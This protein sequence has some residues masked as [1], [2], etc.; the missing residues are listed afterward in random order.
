MNMNLP[1]EL[2]SN[3]EQLI[4]DAALKI[5]EQKGFNATTTSEI[6]KE[7]GIA[8]G[9]I[10]R[11][12]KT[13]KD[14]L[15]KIQ[16]KAIEV[17]GPVMISKPLEI[18]SNSRDKSEKEILKEVLTERVAFLT[19]HL[20]LIKTAFA[21]AL[22]HSDIRESILEN[23][24]KKAKATFDEFFD[25]MVSEGKFRPVDRESA[26]RLFVGSFVMLIAYQHMFN[27]KFTDKELD[28][29]IDNTLDILMYGIL[30]NSNGGSEAK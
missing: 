1:K 5:I 7:A 16:I 17:F 21:E 3:K 27:H 14:I 26:M 13:K 12:F 8:E 6:A 2:H 4:L 30:T 10:F 25:N 15:R 19:K 9:T 23:I 29:T 11:Y 22:F 24:I 18:L 28:L 20:P